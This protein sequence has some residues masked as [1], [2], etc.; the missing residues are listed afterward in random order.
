[1]PGHPIWGQFYPPNLG[2]I[3]H[4]KKKNCTKFEDNQGEKGLS[5]I[6]FAELLGLSYEGY[7]KI[8]LAQRYPSEAT[9]LK[10]AKALKIDP[11]N[12][13]KKL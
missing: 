13:F 7:Q 9:I 3:G 11:A 5:Q 12:L 2:I 1:M 4:V 10:I 6:E 8:E